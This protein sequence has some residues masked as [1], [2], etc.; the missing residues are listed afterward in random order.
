MNRIL[1][2]KE[3]IKTKSLPAAN[4]SASTDAIEIGAGV[5]ETV[6][7]TVSVD[8][9]PSL[10]DG[11]KIT[12]TLEHSDDDVNYV[13]IPELASLVQTGAGGAGAAAVARTVYLPPSVKMFIRAT[14]AVDADGGDNTP[15]S[16]TLSLLF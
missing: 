3:L 15:K 1:Q 6:Q 13:A 14:S 5:F 10:A 8:A 12:T 2:D 4:A 11:K 9:V 7:V 16:V